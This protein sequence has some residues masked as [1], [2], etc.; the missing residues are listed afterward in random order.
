MKASETLPDV[1]DRVTQDYIAKRNKSGLAIGL[2]QQGKTLI[3]GYGQISGVSSYPA[4]ETIFE[5]GSITKVFTGISLAQLEL[6]GVVGLDD[7]LTDHLPPNVSI[8]PEAQAITLRHLAT[9]TSGLPSL[10]HNFFTPTSDPLNPYAAYDTTALYQALATVKLNHP[11][12]R[13]MEYSNLGMGLLGHLLTLKTGTSYEAI[14]KEII[15]HPLGMVD[16]TISLS[17]QQQQRLTPGHDLEGQV[18]PNWELNV[19]AGA[20][21]LRSTP[22]DMLKFIEASLGQTSP[23]KAAIERSQVQQFEESTGA[24]GLAWQLLNLPEGVT[25]HWHNGGTGGYSSFLAID[26]TQQTGI[27][28]LANSGDRLTN[29]NSLDEMGAQI[30]LIAAQIP[31]E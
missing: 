17:F 25:L 21:A 29:D 16:T 24:I 19:L 9:H 13:K 30:L 15:C 12:G 23:V 7:R 3:R 10:P 31:M 27:V 26:R 14:V 6:E 28:L 11:P 20:G 22:K 4:A 8:S 2:F 18:V 5:I 1:V